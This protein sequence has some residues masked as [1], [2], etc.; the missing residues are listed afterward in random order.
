M[1]YKNF[2]NNEDKDKKDDQITKAKDKRETNHSF[3]L[4][5]LVLVKGD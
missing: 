5:S 4:N 3:C 1:T 2:V